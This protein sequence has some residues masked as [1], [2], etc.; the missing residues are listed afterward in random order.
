MKVYSFFAYRVLSRCREG[1]GS[2]LT[3]GYRFRSEGGI[4]YENG[5]LV[6]PKQQAAVEALGVELAQILLKLACQALIP[7]QAERRHD[8]TRIR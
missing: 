2:L 4:G 6:H 5:T 3:Q 7:E 8:L 1:Q